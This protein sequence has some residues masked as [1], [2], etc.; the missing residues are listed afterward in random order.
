MKIIGV[1]R[2]EGV[3]V[4]EENFE[5]VYEK[6]NSS[7][8]YVEDMMGVIYE[9]IKNDPTD[10]YSISILEGL[11]EIALNILHSQRDFTYVYAD[12]EMKDYYM[13][14]LDDRINYMTDV[15]SQTRSS[16]YR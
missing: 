10:E 12:G 4:M 13:E 16:K 6:I 5:V 1:F 9:K 14:R 11:G 2:L 8:S 7:F 15:V 3:K